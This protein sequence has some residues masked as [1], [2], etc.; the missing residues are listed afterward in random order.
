MKLWFD[1]R[2]LKT[3]KVPTNLISWKCDFDTPYAYH[4]LIKNIFNCKSFPFS[5]VVHHNSLV[6]LSSIYEVSA[7]FI[8][9]QWLLKNFW[10]WEKFLSIEKEKMRILEWLS[11]Y[12]S[13][14]MVMN[15]DGLG[16]TPNLKTWF[17]SKLKRPKPIK[18]LWMTF[19]I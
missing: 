4:L 15:S 6:R 2:W 8:L 16:F 7:L 18:P 11:Q 5:T 19:C 12:F 13:M 1:L 14:K 3:T 17:W 10:L 9:A